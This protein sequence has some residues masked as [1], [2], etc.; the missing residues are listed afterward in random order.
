M[1]YQITNTTPVTGNVTAQK[2]QNRFCTIGEEDASQLK[3]GME[4]SAAKKVPGRNA[5]VMKAIVFMEEESR[6]V[7]R[8]SWILALLSSFAIRLNS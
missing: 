3:T 7:A 5:I 8:A 1:K 2:I 6:F 4:K